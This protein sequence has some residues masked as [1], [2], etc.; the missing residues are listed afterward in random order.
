MSWHL[1]RMVA[2]DLE[3]T[4]VSIETDRI[5]TAA[6]IGVGG[7]T[8]TEP[9]TWLADPGIDIPA[10]AAAIHG[11]TTDRARTEGIPAARAVEEITAALARYLDMGVPIVGH[12]VSYD[13]TLLDRECRRHDLPTLSEVI[14]DTVIWPVVDTRVLDT[15]VLP[16]RRRVSEKQ[17]ARQLITLA[18]VYGLAWDEAG[19][20]G[21]EYDALM[22]ARIAYRINQIATMPHVDRPPVVHEAKKQRF[23]EVNDLDL[24]G[25]HHAQIRWAAEQA[26]SLQ[27]YLRKSD[28]HAAVDGSWP[29]IPFKEASDAR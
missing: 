18:G 25:L 20:H 8:A 9:R 16:Y 5:V 1:S 4:G 10:E 7:D 6:V 13:L 26:Q 14:Y 21:A 22:A 2:F 11:I 24:E 29:L 19:A 17:G 28:P 23:D 3:T 12:N 27:T 15:H